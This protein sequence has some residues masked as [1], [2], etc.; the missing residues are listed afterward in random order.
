MRCCGGALGVRAPLRRTCA[1]RLDFSLLVPN[2]SP[3]AMW[4]R[5]CQ[6]DVPVL[7]G[8]VGAAACPRCRT[9]LLKPADAGVALETFDAPPKTV[10]PAA[11]LSWQLDDGAA[12]L[13][14]IERRLRPVTRRED[15]EGPQAS[16][17]PLSRKA[18]PQ[19]RAPTAT[20][21]DDTDDDDV[22][23]LRTRGMSGASVAADI[24][25]VLMIAG[26]ATLAAQMQGLLRPEVWA[27]GVGEAALG[28]A[29]FALGLMR[30]ATQTSQRC[31]ELEREV[32][33]LRAELLN[34][35]RPTT[36]S[37]AAGKSAKSSA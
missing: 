33:E 23:G 4:C 32:D 15:A 28:L 16:S 20:V 1:S 27:W 24:G 14:K 26:A 5:Q 31:G 12:A 7:R 29:L 35:R 34:Q 37:T 8:S 25:L 3:L 17:E 2:S 19:E 18:A 21:H 36:S 9:P 13:R 22:F 11:A 10:R 6:Q 30:L